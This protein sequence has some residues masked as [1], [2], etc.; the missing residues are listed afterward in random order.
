MVFDARRYSYRHPFTLQMMRARNDIDVDQRKASRV[1]VSGWISECASIRSVGVSVHLW[2]LER[3][4][5]LLQKQV[6]L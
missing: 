3:A 5:F 2:R 4:M 6:S 1:R